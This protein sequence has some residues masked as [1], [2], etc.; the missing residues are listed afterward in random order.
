MLM[1]SAVHAG[2]STENHR[3]IK[4]W[5]KFVV[6]ELGNIASPLDRDTLPLLNVDLPQPTISSERTGD[7]GSVK[8]TTDSEEGYMN[9][10]WRPISHW[11]T[12]PSS[13]SR[14]D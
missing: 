8:E 1:N 9:F 6:T 5:E 4:C 7:R 13:P 2:P 14:S 3:S 10:T 12:P 11:P